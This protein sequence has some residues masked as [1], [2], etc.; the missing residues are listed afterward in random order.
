MNTPITRDELRLA[1]LKFDLARAKTGRD[2][3][4]GRMAEEDADIKFEND[5]ESVMSLIDQALI[6]AK[7]Q[8]AL[9]A[10]KSISNQSERL[11]VEPI[12]GIGIKTDIVFT[13]AISGHIE[14]L[15]AKLNQDK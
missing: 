15:E 13:S 7:D 1:I 12:G 14:T 10:L 11:R 2:V 8:G 3:V 6:Q 5:L 9:E 4:L